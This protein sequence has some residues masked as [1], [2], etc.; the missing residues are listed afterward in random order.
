[1]RTSSVRRARVIS[2]VYFGLR[3]FKMHTLVDVIP[4]LL[5][6]S[7]LFFFSGLVAFL[8]P[9]NRAITWLMVAVLVVF[10]VMYLTITV[11]PLISLDSPY[12]TPLSGMGW[13]LWQQARAMFSPKDETPSHTSMEDALRAASSR[14]TSRRDEL[15]V[16]WTLASLTGDSELLKFL[17]AIPDA[18]SGP[19]GLRSANFTSFSPFWTAKV[20]ISRSTLVPKIFYSRRTAFSS[21]TPSA[22]VVKMLV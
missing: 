7:L 6:M 13:R 4:M 14:E 20:T 5:H 19:G 2:Y 22:V 3:K 21:M 1:M 17:E 12:F 8:I 10:L 9:V 15:A 16:Q 11:L 18:M